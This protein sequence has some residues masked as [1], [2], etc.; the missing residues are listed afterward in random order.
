MRR[1]GKGF[2][3]IE[4]PL[5][6]TILVQPL[7][8]DD[9]E[10]EEDEDDNE[11]PAS[12]SP[13]SPIHESSPSPP[14]HIPSPPQ[15][16]DKVAQALKIVKLKQRVKK[17]EKKRR[18][19]SSGLNRLR[20]F[21]TSQR[22]ETSNDTVMDAHEDASKQG[23]KIG[24]MEDDVTAAKEVNAAE[25]IVFDDEEVTMT[26]AQTLIKMKGKKQRL[27]DE[28]MAKRLKDEEIEQAVAREKQEKEDLERAKV[29]QQK[30]DQKQENINWNNV[31]EQMKEKHLDNIKA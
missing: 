26:M 10:V 9:A 25:P 14:D 22:V 3:G 12:P 18:S 20:K 23:G 15:E 27:L 31:A 11:V 4:T 2:S 30:Y 24:R 5:F 17:L 21:G 29:L 7:V 13:P 1:I 6:D 19:K 8:H 16:Q 28:Q